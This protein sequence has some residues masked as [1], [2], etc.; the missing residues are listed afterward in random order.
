MEFPVSGDTFSGVL[1][2]VVPLVD[3]LTPEVDGATSNFSDSFVIDG[4]LIN[5][6][7]WAGDFSFEL[8]SFA[9]GC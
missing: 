2:L 9:A 4:D 8:S 5:T 7:T 1:I 6:L 3:L